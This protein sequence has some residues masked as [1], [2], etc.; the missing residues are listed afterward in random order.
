[1]SGFI[2]ADTHVL[3]TD[4]SW[5][6]LDPTERD[7]RP[8]TIEFQ[9]E[10][11]SGYEQMR[12]FG[13][14]S[15][16]MWIIDDNV[17]RRHPGDGRASGFG[18]EYQAEAM[19]LTD[20]SVRLRDMDELGVDKQIVISTFFIGAELERPITEAALTRSWNRW[21][22]DRVADSGG[23][24]NWLVVPGTR[25][26]ERALQEIEFGRANGAV[27]VMLKG[28]EHGMYLN[29]PY[30]YPLYAKAQ[31]LDMTIGVH[32]GFAWRRADVR[33]ISNLLPTPPAYV[34]NLAALMKGFYAVLASDLHTRFPRLRWVFLEGGSTWVQMIFQQHQR[35]ISTS[36][37]GS[38]VNS[39]NRTSVT[40]D[41]LDTAELM[42][43][44]KMYVA[45]EVDEEIAR[46]ASITGRSQLIFGTD[47]GHNDVG[48]D[49]TGLELVTKREDL[50]AD[51][52]Q[53][54]VRDNALAAFALH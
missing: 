52:A 35:L 29:D 27:G 5:D 10:V 37:P 50:D 36:K 14:R 30:F 49:P 18:K 47:Y 31:E 54:I 26:M 20:P 45:C 3:E 25:T 9:D 51:L 44:K 38:F 53:A 41:P 43:E 33:D 7:L 32:L 13:G 15:K 4:A 1:M 2:D 11:H 48:C 42:A 28:V 17:S 39:G 16:Q 34:D 21:M 12:A 40:I 46:I 24:L 8:K 6:Y 19:F 22:A 23:R